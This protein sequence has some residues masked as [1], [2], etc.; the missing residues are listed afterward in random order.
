MYCRC[1]PCCSY[2]TARSGPSG[3]QHARRSERSKCQVAHWGSTNSLYIVMFPHP[4]THPL[5]SYDACMYRCMCTSARAYLYC[6]V[7]VYRISH[8]IRVDIYAGTGIWCGDWSQL[9]II[10]RHLYIYYPG[11]SPSPLTPITLTSSYLLYLTLCG[12]SSI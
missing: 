4:H 3:P 1:I 8:I 12:Y 11:P 6:I 2:V 7:L 10:L 9:R 5:Y